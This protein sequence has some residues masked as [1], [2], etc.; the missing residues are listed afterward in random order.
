M[1]RLFDSKQ[2]SHPGMPSCAGVYAVCVAY[3]DKKL[4]ER[5]VYI[6]SSGNIFKRVMNPNHP[7]RL[8]FDRFEEYMVYIKHIKTES[9][10]ELEKELI[11]TY[12]PLLNK[13]HKKSGGKESIS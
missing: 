3:F 1:V 4:K 10:R 6:G 12:K 8:C 5:I 7:Y 2:H 11:A 9:F 13:Q